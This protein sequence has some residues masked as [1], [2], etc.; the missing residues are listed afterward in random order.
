MSRLPGPAVGISAKVPQYSFSLFAGDAALVSRWE[1]A[2]NY[3]ASGGLLSLLRVN[4][5][6]IRLTV[7]GSTSS[8]QVKGTQGTLLTLSNVLSL[9]TRFN[10]SLKVEIQRFPTGSGFVSAAIIY[11]TDV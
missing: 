1:E 7:D 9:S 4:A 6:M 3:T 5:E 2:L 8:F 11:E 10:E